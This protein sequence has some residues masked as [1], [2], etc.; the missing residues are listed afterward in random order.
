[1][2][3]GK[4]SW[5]SF[6]QWLR[7]RGLEG[8]KFI[9]GDKCLGMLEAVRE[10]FPEAKYQRCVSHFYQDTFSIVP[11][12]KVKNVVKMLEAIHAQKSKKTPHEKSAAVL[13]ELRAMKLPEP[14]RKVASGIEGTLTY[15]DFSP[16]H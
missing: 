7:G 4:A 10:V 2:K 12:S 6:L 8:V 11:K 1:M 5:V 14:A 15:C 3:E 13:A 9:V 16:E